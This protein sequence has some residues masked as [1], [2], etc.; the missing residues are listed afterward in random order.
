[1]DRAEVGTQFN[2]VK[3]KGVS[4]VP[5]LW[6]PSLYIEVALKQDVRYYSSQVNR[7]LHADGG[8]KYYS[9]IVMGRENPQRTN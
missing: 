9:C 5:H 3:T 7:G 8:E 2:R 6:E 4:R 1:M